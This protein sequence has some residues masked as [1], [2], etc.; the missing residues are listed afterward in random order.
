MK[1]NAL[2]FVGVAVFALGTASASAGPCT[3]E[4]DSLVR[5]LSAK[6]AGSGPTPGAGGTQPALPPSAQHPP[7]A[8]MNQAASGTATSPQD[9]RGQTAGQA[10]VS[11]GARDAP[12]QRPPTAVM[13]QATESQRAPVAADQ[14]PPTAAMS[15]AT[16]TQGA[17]SSSASGQN[18]SEA[19]HALNRARMFDQQGREAECME[20]VRQARQLA[21]P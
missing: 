5:I 16:R 12:A 21:G 19:S 2:K 10:S 9:V 18:T 17:A 11:Q 1:T 3:T 4:I 8:S 15:E 13:G 7:T 20:A 6:D 14:H